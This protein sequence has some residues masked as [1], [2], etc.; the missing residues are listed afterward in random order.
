LAKL[1]NDEALRYIKEQLS[2]LGVFID[3]NSVITQN[4]AGQ[5]GDGT[6]GPEWKQGADRKQYEQYKYLI[7][8]IDIILNVSKSPGEEQGEDIITTQLYRVVFKRETGVNFNIEIPLYTWTQKRRRKRKTGIG[9][10][11]CAVF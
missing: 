9:K 1:R 4:S 7:V 2:A 10:E 11:R 6:S 3:G 8:N 5:N